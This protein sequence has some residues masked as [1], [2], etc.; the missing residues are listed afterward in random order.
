[1]EQL[2]Q[3]YGI[4]SMLI[5]KIESQYQILTTTKCTKIVLTEATMENLLRI[6]FL[7]KK[8]A[9]KIIGL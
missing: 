1:M 4:D 2:N 3:V 7:T 5:S 6:P 8:E 9:K